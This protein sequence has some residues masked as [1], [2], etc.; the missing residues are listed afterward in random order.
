[1]NFDKNTELAA[2]SFHEML[3]EYLVA[4]DG[5]CALIEYVADII[6]QIKTEV[7]PT[8]PMGMSVSRLIYN[9]RIFRVQF[10][11]G[12]YTTLE[13]WKKSLVF[14][15]WYVPPH[16]EITQGEIAVMVGWNEAS[17]KLAILACVEYL[18]ENRTGI[19]IERKFSGL[20]KLDDG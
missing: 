6:M 14:D 15:I 19:D 1:M 10:D 11:Y 4:S 20:A 8:D 9:D 12:K 17:I 7:W 3:F 16:H 2:L 13:G 18:V 5:P